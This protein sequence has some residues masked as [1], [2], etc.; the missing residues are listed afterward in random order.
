[1]ATPC[2]VYVSSTLGAR[3][4]DT[5]TTLSGCMYFCA[6]RDHV[7]GERQTIVIRDTAKG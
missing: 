6:I 7:S 1:M 2:L 5:S 4:I 3:E